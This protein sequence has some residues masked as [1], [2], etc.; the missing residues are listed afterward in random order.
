MSKKIAAASVALLV[1][2]GI[3]LPGGMYINTMISGMVQD[4]VDEGLLAIQ[5][6]FVPIASEMV[7]DMGPAEVLKQIRETAI[8]AIEEMI[9]QIGPAMA[10]DLI[11]E[12]ALPYI[13]EIVEA[14][15]FTLFVDMV[16]TMDP[17]WVI[18]G[19]VYPESL[20]WDDQTQVW[21]IVSF[22]M[23]AGVMGYP[24]IQGISQYWGE[25]LDYG[26]AKVNLINGT[27]TLP[28]VCKNLEVGDGVQEMLELYD[29]SVGNSSSEA[30]IVAGYE[31]DNWHQF[32]CLIEYIRDYYIPD[33]IPMLVADLNDPSSALYSEIPEY[34]D[35]DVSGIAYMKLLEQ[36]ADCQ[37]FEG[38]VD[39]HL[40]AEEIP[41]GTYGLEIN[42]PDPSNITIDS[43]YDLWDETNEHSLLNMD[44]ILEWFEANS[45]GTVKSD[46]ELTFNLTSLQ[47]QLILDWLWLPGGFSDHLLPVLIESEYGFGV[48]MTQLSENVLYELWANGT[49]L[50]MVMYPG[51]LDFNEFI[52][53]FGE[54]V[55][56]F[57]VGVPIPTNMSLEVVKNLW[58]E[59]NPSSIL[60]LDTGIGK[61]LEANTNDTIKSELTNSFGLKSYQT[62]MILD[63]FWRGNESIRYYLVPLLL[64]S[65]FGYNMSLAEFA[66]L[67]LLEQWCN[68]TIMGMKMFEGGI[69]FA[70]FI[71]GLPTGTTG[72]EVGVPDP[73]IISVESALSLWDNDS[74]FSLITGK[75]IA[76]WWSVVAS[77][78]SEWYEPLRDENGLTGDQMD[79]ILSWL[80]IFRD[81]VMPYLAQYEMGLP[82]DSTSLGNTI[83]MGTSVIGAACIGLASLGFA[84]NV[85]ARRRKPKTLPP[86]KSQKSK[87]FSQELFLRGFQESSGASARVDAPPGEPKEALGKDLRSMDVPAKNDNVDLSN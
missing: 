11:R 24:E 6:E 75:G 22:S 35:M 42:R 27:D 52:G 55:T 20:F 74:E 18:L 79:L 40:V 83:Q 32:E 41:N 49:V 21:G 53:G 63:Y 26:S 1:F 59:T 2:G 7:K 54:P 81:T 17:V 3:S 48:S 33:V 60:N 51:G 57:E 38:G 13:E 28:G 61:W 46:L 82:M 76:K 5:D 56:G 64:E 39:F 62:Q 10:L 71:E 68:G 15:F 29:D 73:T 77:P 72:F 4:N 30:A 58:N 78:S 9:H 25:D 12:A 45:T 47:G 69:D 34:Q 67:L 8:P 50:D 31:L 66:N 70:E 14:T 84:G 37:L 36:W 23:A 16:R 44:G 86:K 87:Q 19:T 43:C 80:P 65:E 85:V